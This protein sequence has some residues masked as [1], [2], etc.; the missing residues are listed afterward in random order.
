[1]ALTVLLRFVQPV[2]S[3]TSVWPISCV[4]QVRFQLELVDKF[5]VAGAAGKSVTA[6][7]GR[8]FWMS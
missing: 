5:P 2:L 1:M 6:L 3:S 7:V 4:G 8:S